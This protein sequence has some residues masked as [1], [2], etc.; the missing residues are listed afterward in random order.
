[1]ACDLGVGGGPGPRGA[2]RG[3]GGV[4]VA[5]AVWRDLGPG[6]LGT[7]RGAPGAARRGASGRVWGLGLG[8]T[9]PPALRTLSV[10]LCRLSRQLS[11][12]T[13]TGVHGDGVWPCGVHLVLSLCWAC[14]VTGA[15]Q[16][17]NAH[18]PPG[19]SA[20]GARA[21]VQQERSAEKPHTLDLKT[22][23][24]E[25]LCL[26]RRWPQAGGGGWTS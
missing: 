7:G 15:L 3:G 1:M 21:R 24:T 13:P 11:T 4:A 8:T 26:C 19:G 10:R 18:G 23:L 14:E 17:P 6:G 20:L 5:V 25:A 2:G 9:L 22:M 16:T 12:P